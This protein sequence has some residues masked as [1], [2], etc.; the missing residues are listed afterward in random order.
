MNQENQS[1]LNKWKRTIKCC[2]ES[3]KETA[4]NPVFKADKEALESLLPKILALSKALDMEN[5]HAE[6]KK[7]IKNLLLD[8]CL[9]VCVNLNGYG[10]VT[11][12][13]TLAKLGDYNKSSLGKGKEADVLQ[14]CQ[15]VADKARE[16][17]S[18]LN[19]KRGMPETFLT[20]LED[21]VKQY[22]TAIPEPKDAQKE[23]ST[24]LAELDKIFVEGEN[25]FKLLIGSSINL[26]P[27]AKEFLV[28][29]NKASKHIAPQ[30]SPTKINFLV[31]N[32]ITKQKISDFL[33][34]SQALGVRSIMNISDAATTI[35]PHKNA[36]FIIEREGF[37]SAI[38]T[39]LHIKKGQI[40]TFRVK[41]TPI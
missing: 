31:T 24:A 38:L 9:D 2:N 18:D 6:N 11:N 14:R 33:Q 1:T 21:L 7:N 34:T 3:P 41:L 23:K 36:D 27:I 40:N 35:L 8:A 26:K 17:F 16:I 22:E 15:D 20:T 32:S 19:V 28:R 37:E 13:V 12:N 39:G 5:D 4:L 25:L 10:L 29:F 30:T